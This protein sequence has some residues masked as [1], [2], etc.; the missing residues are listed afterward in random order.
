[1]LSKDFL[2]MLDLFSCAAR[3][4]IPERRAINV[5][6]VY[7]SA[8]S[9]G[10]SELVFLSLDSLYKSNSITIDSALYKMMKMQTLY[11]ISFDN[12]SKAVLQA[13]LQSLHTNGIE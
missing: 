8:L 5:E 4:E 6:S 1:M 3:G 9:H 2:D 7:Q 10:V 11:S 13:V 12:R